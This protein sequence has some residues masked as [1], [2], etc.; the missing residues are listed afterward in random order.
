MEAF[1]SISVRR[2]EKWREGG[3]KLFIDNPTSYRL[4]GNGTQGAV[5]HL[6]EVRCVKIFADPNQKIQESKILQAAQKLPFIPRLYESGP[7]YIIMEYL[8]G[9]DL[10]TFLKENGCLSEM[11]TRQILTIIREMHLLSHEMGFKQK[12]AVTQIDT[13]MRHLIVTEQVKIKVVDHV[14]I[15]RQNEHPIKMFQEFKDLGMLEALLMQAKK[16]D[17]TIFAAWEKAIPFHEL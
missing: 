8:K 16:I 1:T 15:L 10:E 5:F 3:E 13:P 17:P 12:L 6:D 11:V 7:N 2:N 9:P 4:I 14:D